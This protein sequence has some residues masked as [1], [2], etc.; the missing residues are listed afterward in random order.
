MTF[1]ITK[2]FNWFKDYKNLTENSDEAF[3]EAHNAQN[4][5]NK[6]FILFK[7]FQK[8]KTSYKNSSDDDINSEIKLKNK[9]NYQKA[10]H[11]NLIKSKHFSE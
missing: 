6:V 3:H 5:I 4:T 7:Y 1:N 9:D 11:C 8:V 2:V 10:S